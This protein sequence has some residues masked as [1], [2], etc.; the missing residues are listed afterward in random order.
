MHFLLFLKK[1]NNLVKSSVKSAF[2]SI[3]EE[4]GVTSSLLKG[5]CGAMRSII[6]LYIFIDS[7]FPHLRTTIYLTKYFTYK[8]KGIFLNS[9]EILPVQR[10]YK[11]IVHMIEWLIFY[12]RHVTWNITNKRGKKKL[13]FLRKYQKFLSHTS[14]FDCWHR[15]DVILYF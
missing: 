12:F 11:N 9:H 13:N 5:V 8:V 10:H 7:L 2:K 15:P 4:G 6:S 3:W 1:F 14:L